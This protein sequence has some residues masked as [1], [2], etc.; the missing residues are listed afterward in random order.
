[1][2][3]M[4]DEK[5]LMEAEKAK[6]NA[7]APYSKFRVGAALL[8][9]DGKVFAGCNVENA[10]YGVTNC[11][12]RTALYAAIAAGYRKFSAI[13]ITSNSEQHTS[14]CGV[15]RQALVEFGPDMK[16]IM[17]NVNG[18]YIVR[19]A[20]ELLPLYFSLDSMEVNN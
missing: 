11:A 12:E 20:A 4:E 18:E 6:K 15:C 1:M 5:L 17:G 2:F 10:A 14:P 3:F 8:T 7:Y 19:R 9:N 13:A 16:V